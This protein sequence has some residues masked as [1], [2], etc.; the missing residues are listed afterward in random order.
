[1]WFHLFFCCSVGFGETVETLKRCHFISFSARI[2]SVELSNDANLRAAFNFT[3]SM[4]LEGSCIK[5]AESGSGHNRN[6]RAYRSKT[7]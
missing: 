1:M 2:I 5:R 6:R 3:V 7:C 4:T